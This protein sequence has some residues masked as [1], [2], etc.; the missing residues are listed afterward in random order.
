MTIETSGY[1]GL[2]NRRDDY[3]LQFR[4][5]SRDL[6]DAADGAASG[7][8][9]NG[10]RFG[11][12]LSRVGG[13]TDVD[14]FVKLWNAESGATNDGEK[15]ASLVDRDEWRA[16]AVAIVNHLSKHHPEIVRHLRDELGPA[17]DATIETLAFIRSARGPSAT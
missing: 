3:R 7:D 11:G 10:L 4:A 13:V 5:I 2:Q 12:P 14:D 8:D 17:A 15:I 1:L 9:P 16:R 6:M